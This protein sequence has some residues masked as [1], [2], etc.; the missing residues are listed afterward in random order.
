M[1][2]QYRT[3]T[4]TE[5]NSER[6]LVPDDELVQKALF[7][8]KVFVL[9]Y[10]RYADRVYRYSLARVKHVEDAQD[11]TSQTF[12]AALEGLKTFRKDG[13]F[14]AWLFGI[15]SRKAARTFR[16][17]PTDSIDLIPEIQLSEASLEDLV[18]QQLTLESALSAIDRLHHDRGEAIRLHYFAG[19]SPDEIGVVMGKSE[20]AVRMLIHRGMRDLKERLIPGTKEGDK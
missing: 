1:L 9:L 19:L 8:M 3:S 4:R 12:L 16:Y 15:A 14:A 17:Q 5:D 11:I 13:T 10:Q 7:D 6:Q 20:G 2:T 18:N